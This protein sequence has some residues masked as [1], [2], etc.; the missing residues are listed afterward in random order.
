M[1]VNGPVCGM[2]YRGYNMKSKWLW[3]LALALGG[4]SNA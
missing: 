2:G 1:A 3:M 4:Y